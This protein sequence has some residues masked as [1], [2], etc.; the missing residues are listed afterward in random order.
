M[1][2]IRIM[3]ILLLAEF[4]ESLMVLFLLYDKFSR[5]FWLFFLTSQIY[6]AKSK[7]LL[8]YLVVVIVEETNF[9][10]TFVSAR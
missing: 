5:G 4:P 2:D 6:F 9:K 1:N 7:A 3:D 8:K 10:L